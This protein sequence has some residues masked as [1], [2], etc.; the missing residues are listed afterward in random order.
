MLS[1]SEACEPVIGGVEWS[2]SVWASWIVVRRAEIDLAL[3]TRRRGD[4]PGPGT[5]ASEALRR[6]RSFA[7]SAL[8]RG[9]AG[10]PALDGLRVDATVAAQLVEDWCR[11]A[12]DVAG[13]RND[14]LLR[15]LSPLFARFRSALLG[16][17]LAS[18]AQRAPR[19]ARRAVG[20][21]IDRIAD[22]FLALDV[23]TLAIADANP[24]AAALLR[25][26]RDSLI[27][28]DVMRFL[29]SDARDAW[30]CALEPL[31]ESAAPRRFRSTLIDARGD[32]IAVDVHATRV[33]SRE[34][35]LALVV[36]RPV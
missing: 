15:Q 20:G 2:Q 25:V 27:G 5:P 7:A 17:E 18:E 12:G 19:I 14:E 36:A 13:E 32:S 26:N 28:G 11:A 8:R 24:A 1:R 4:L 22:A 10:A 3:A 33:A 31:A 34:R 23:D 9:D 21:A 6:F 16:T 30:R 35:V 29:S